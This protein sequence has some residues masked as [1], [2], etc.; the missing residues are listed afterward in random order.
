MAWYG[1]PSPAEP[2]LALARLSGLQT[3][4]L[5][6]GWLYVAFGRRW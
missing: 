1:Q 3:W 2:H 5:D 6:L 4:L